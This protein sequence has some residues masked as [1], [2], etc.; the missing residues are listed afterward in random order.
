MDSRSSS[1]P[2]EPDRASASCH[3]LA[4]RKSHLERSPARADVHFKTV[5]V[6]GTKHGRSGVSI[7]EGE[8]VEKIP[9][10]TEGKRCKRV[11]KNGCYWMTYSETEMTAP[12]NPSPTL[13]RMETG[14]ISER[15][16]KCTRQTCLACSRCRCHPHHM[17]LQGSVRGLDQRSEPELTAEH[18]K[19]EHLRKQGIRT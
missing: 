15:R 5:V 8:R 4:M 10:A 19:Q 16:E 17:S 3:P 11:L 2:I 1:S 13:Q 12:L 9:I 7:L 6:A 18:E 14:S